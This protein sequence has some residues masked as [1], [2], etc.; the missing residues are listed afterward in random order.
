MSEKRGLA[1][2]GGD[3][4]QIAMARALSSMGYPVCVW[5]LGHQEEKS[6]PTVAEKEPSSIAPQLDRI[7]LSP[8]KAATHVGESATVCGTLVEINPLGDMNFLNFDR[9]FPNNIF[10]CGIDDEDASQFMGINSLI[11]KKICVT[12]VLRK[13]GSKTGMKLTKRTQLED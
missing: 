3:S 4:R 8:E 9:P 12:G 1:V 6:S 11:G 10:T 7:V 2:L 13:Y 5:G